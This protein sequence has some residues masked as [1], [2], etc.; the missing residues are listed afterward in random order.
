MAYGGL[1][2]VVDAVVS[3]PILLTAAAHHGAGRL[4][5]VRRARLEGV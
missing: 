5:C 3:L 4:L 1:V 2:D